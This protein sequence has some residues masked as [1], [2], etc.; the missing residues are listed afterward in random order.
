M[1]QPIGM[2]RRSLVAGAVLLAGLAVFGRA[3]ARDPR[4]GE[5]A[6]KEGKVV[7]YTSLALQSAEKVAK[8]FETAHPGVKVEVHRTGSER[9]LQ[10]VM[11]EMQA[12]IKNADV[13]H[14][15]DAGHFVLFKDKKLLAKYTPAGVDR[16]PDGFKDKDGFY[17][18]LRATV[19]CIAYN[20]K[21]VSAA[22]APK[23][24]KDL[25]DPRWKGKLVTAHPGYSGVI[26][27]HVLA[28]VTLF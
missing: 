17:Y 6:K 2:T 26:A 13:I 15:S 4:V 25:L 5:G 1:S 7:W 24:W 21:V 22:E 28:L 14:T 8:L 16:F 9:I 23:T 19:N 12:N 27:T 10:R 11:Q 20:T 3:D 18:G